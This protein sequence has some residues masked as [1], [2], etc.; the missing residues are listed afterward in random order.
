MK[1]GNPP[2]QNGSTERKEPR[3]ATHGLA[4]ALEEMAVDEFDERTRADRRDGR[5]GGAAE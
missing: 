2:R 5:G 3:R 4:V 1:R